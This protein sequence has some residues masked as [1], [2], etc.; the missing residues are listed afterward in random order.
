MTAK[1]KRA[2]QIATINKDDLDALITTLPARLM[3][4]VSEGIVW[5]LKLDA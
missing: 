4:R 3:E 2:S 1:Q 5:F